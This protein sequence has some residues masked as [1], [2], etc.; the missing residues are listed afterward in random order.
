MELRRRLFTLNISIA[1][2]PSMR[3]ELSRSYSRQRWSYN[4]GYRVRFSRKPFLGT[5]LRHIRDYTG[6]RF[7]HRA[8]SWLYGQQAKFYVRIPACWTI[9]VSSTSCSVSPGQL[10]VCHPT[11]GNAGRNRNL[12]HSVLDHLYFILL[13]YSSCCLRFSSSVL[14][15]P[16]YQRIRGDNVNVNQKNLTW[17]E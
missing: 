8:V 11:P 10:H 13:R 9:H 6:H 14:P 12:R 15:T 7:G 16:S 3:A 2:M 5:G 1:G 4:D 17:L